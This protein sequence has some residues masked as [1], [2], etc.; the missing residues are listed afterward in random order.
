MTYEYQET[1]WDVAD[2]QIYCLDDELIDRQTNTQFLLRGPKPKN[3]EEGKYFACIGAAQTFGRFCE[4][5]YPALLEEKLSIQSLNLGRG[6]AGI[7]FFSKEN[8]KLLKYVNSAKFAIIQIMS[9]RSESNSLFESK[10]LGTYRRR[11]D[12]T[13]IGCDDAYKKLLEENDQDYVAKIV[14]ETRHNWVNHFKDFLEQITVPR[15]LFWFSVRRPHYRE[16]YKSV[17][18]LFGDFPQ[19]VNSAMVRQIRNYSDNYVECTSTRGTPHPLVNRF[20]SKP[21][22]I[23]DKWSGGAWSKNWYY[24]SPE[25]H[26]DAAN[27][28]EKACKVYLNSSEVSQRSP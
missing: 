12:G 3:L 13:H 18:G 4:K 28:L 15:V 1:D 7:S 27:A 16:K 10:G 20:T 6:G 5:P 22:T 19:L 9:G 21:I 26:I 2:Y 25:M 14:A 11:S 8:E 23:E 24:P 17:H